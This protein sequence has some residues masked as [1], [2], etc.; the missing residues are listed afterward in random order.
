[1]DNIT[2]FKRLTL[3]LFGKPY[4]SFPM[5]TEVDVKS[6]AMSVIPED[7]ELDEAWN[8]LHAAEDVAL[9]VVASSTLCE[10]VVGLGRL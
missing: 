7:H 8:G 9:S 2:F 5:P 10:A 3:P 6:I 1:M 4:S